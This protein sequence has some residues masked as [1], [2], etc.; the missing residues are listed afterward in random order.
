MEEKTLSE[1]MDVPSAAAKETALTWN[2]HVKRTKR[3]SLTTKCVAAV[4]TRRTRKKSY[5]QAGS[6]D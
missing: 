4:T 3:E 5:L 2:G 6:A 1:G